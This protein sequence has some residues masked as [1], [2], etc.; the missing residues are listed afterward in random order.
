MGLM[1]NPA[2]T[3]T[4]NNGDIASE[5][6]LH[7]FENGS[8]SIR[9]PVYI[10]PELNSQ[11]NNPLTLTDAGRLPTCFGTGTYTIVLESADEVQ[12]WV[13]NDIAIDDMTGQFADYSSVKIYLANEIVRYVDGN[14]YFSL[15]NNNRGNAPSV[16]SEWWSQIGFL[17]FFNSSKADANAYKL[18]D[19]VI[20]GGFL[21]RSL[22]NNNGDT[23]PSAKWANLTF[24]DSVSGNFTVGGDLTVD[25][26]IYALGSISSVGDIST[27]SDLVAAGGELVVGD[28]V[29]D[30]AYINKEAQISTDGENYYGI[31]TTEGDLP[32]ITLALTSAYVPIDG[33]IKARVTQG[34]LYIYGGVSCSSASATIAPV[35]VG[36]RKVMQIAV[37]KSV[38]GFPPPTPEFAAIDAVDQGSNFYLSWLHPEAGHDLYISVAIPL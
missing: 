23:P 37:P 31:A 35:P 12:Q 13:R 7:F 18:N 2:P 36:Y 22:E 26:Q 27:D 24:N 30:T 1:I 33:G 19:I 6:K 10:D 9:K 11:L 16:N 21:Y 8:T 38:A 20:D 15:K 4:L 3:F 14:Y 29:G 32:E 17:E 25:N 34:I 28:G 5:G